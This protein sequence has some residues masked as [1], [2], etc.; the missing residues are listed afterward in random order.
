MRKAKIT[1]A[2]ATANLRNQQ[3]YHANRTIGVDYATAGF[4]RNK[5]F[6]SDRP[7]ELDEHF[8]FVNN[9]ERL[10]KGYGLEIE[11]ECNNIN[12]D[13]VLVY[14]L[15]TIVWSK[16]DKDL[17][18]HQHDGSLGGNSSDENITQIMTKEFIR[19]SYPSW[20][21]AF[22]AMNKI[23]IK[24]TTRCGMHCNMS[25]G[26]FGSKRQEQL[27]CVK[28]LC[29]FI[30]HF[31]LLS[32]GLLKRDSRNTYYC[33]RMSEFADLESAKNADIEHSYS[34]HG[35]S[36]NNGHLN[37]GQGRFEL[38]LVGGQT[39][40]AEFRNTMETIFHLVD[41]VKN[42]SWDAIQDLTK[43]FKGCNQYVLSRLRLCRDN[44]LLDS[45]T[46][47]AIESNYDASVSF[48]NY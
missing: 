26:L 18:K 43:V 4:N 27:T 1:Q 19:N 39:S 37:D 46:Y 17:F 29:F 47:A 2:V 35:V 3:G 5:Y 44:G 33:Q 21:Y 20:K 23:G 10:L 31:Y 8:N 42:C 24:A 40:Y 28:K 36:C 14:I 13:N 34:S 45:E 30:N 38:R 15:D 11:L 41:A 12:S 22:D 6:T 9:P 32:C 16:F 7:I 48:G 25:L